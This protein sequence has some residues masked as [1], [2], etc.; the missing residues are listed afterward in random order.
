MQTFLPEPTFE[1]SARCLDNMRLG[2]QRVEAKQIYTALTHTDYG[3]RH[4]P[5]VRMWEGYEGVLCRYGWVICMEWRGRGFRDSLMPFFWERK[6]SDLAPMPTWYDQDFIRSH[7]SNLLRKYPAW[8]SQFG[9]NVPNDLPYVWPTHRH[10]QE[11]RL[12]LI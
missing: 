7:R 11:C 3:W 9:W 8:Y 12:P 4:H 2:K 6:E 10:A 5:A 1:A